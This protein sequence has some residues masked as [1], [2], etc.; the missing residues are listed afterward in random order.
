MK[1]QR[2]KVWLAGLLCAVVM[3]AAAQ[4][5]APPPGS[6]WRLVM[7]VRDGQ[8]QTPPA[9][10]TLEFP[11]KGGVA[12]SAGVNRY[13][14]QVRVEPDGT[15]RWSARGLASTR[16]AGEPEAMAFEARYLHALMR[17]TSARVGED[18]RLVLEDAD[19]T[20][21]LLFDPEP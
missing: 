12:G 20:R 6:A 4:T 5:A 13:T 21:W 2:W 10:V 7:L 11:G 1:G 3:D 16:M 8:E 19:G 17:A 14:G 18:G 9:L 15:L